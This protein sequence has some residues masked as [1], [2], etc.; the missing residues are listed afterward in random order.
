MN[1]FKVSACFECV[2]GVQ[3][4]LYVQLPP[5]D[6]NYDSNLYKTNKATLYVMADRFPA[7]DDIESGKSNIEAQTIY[8]VSAPAAQAI[9]VHT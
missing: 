8:L 6:S 3:L 2:G 1:T 7:L 9:T 5:E 4:L